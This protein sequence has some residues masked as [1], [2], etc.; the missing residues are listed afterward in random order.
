MPAIKIIGLW[1]ENTG[2]AL[3]TVRLGAKLTQRMVAKRAGYSVGQIRKA[4]KGEM[5]FE[6]FV[7]ICA[8][9]G[10]QPSEVLRIAGV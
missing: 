8:A 7:N 9:L 2:L 5:G 4:E 3:R 1:K 6:C 10:T